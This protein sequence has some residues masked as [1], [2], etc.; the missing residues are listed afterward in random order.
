MSRLFLFSLVAGAIGAV[1]A[2]RKGRSW[3]LWLLLCALFPFLLIVVIMLPPAL[4]R[5]LTKKCP[6]CAEIIR[7]EATVCKYCGKDLPIEM[8]QCPGCGRFV[9]DGENCSE[10]RRPLR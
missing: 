9:P 7:H 1:V 6:Y 5:G 8:V 3:P 10:C 2:E 4:A